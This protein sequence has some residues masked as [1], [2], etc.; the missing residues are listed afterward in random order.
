M[1]YASSQIAI[2]IIFHLVLTCHGFITELT[3]VFAGLVTTKQSQP[4]L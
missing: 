2:E 4:Q 3:V 1:P